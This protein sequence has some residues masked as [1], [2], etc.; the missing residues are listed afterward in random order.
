M[1]LGVGYARTAD[2]TKVYVVARYKTHGNVPE[3][4]SAQVTKPAYL[5]RTFQN[6]CYRKY[7]NS[8]VTVHVFSGSSRRV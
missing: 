2:R 7:R 8:I 5:F 4:Y 3:Q 6:N 1:R